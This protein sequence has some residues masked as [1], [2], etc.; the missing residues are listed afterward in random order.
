MSTD[1]APIAADPLGAA[2]PQVPVAGRPAEPGATGPSGRGRFGVLYGAIWLVY[3]SYP[4]TSAWSAEPGWRR[5]V[6][7]LST[8]LFAAVFVAALV[9]RRRTRGHP[10]RVPTVWWWATLAVELLLVVG[11]GLAADE[12]ALTGLV[13]MAVTAVFVLPGRSA[14]VVVAALVLLGEAVPRLLT[15]WDSIDSIGVQIVLASAAIFGFTQLM[16]RNVELARARGELADLAVARERERIARDVHDLLGHSLTVITVKAELAG[17]LLEV[18]RA[19]AAQEVADV[20]A[21]ARGALADVRATVAGFRAIGLA[22][23]LASARAVLTAAGLEVST[24]T[25]VDAVPESL[26]TLFAWVVREGVTNVLRHADAR[27]CEITVDARAVVVADDGHGP[28]G[29]PQAAAQ[30]VP[31]SG[32]VG[33]RERAA[34]AGAS[35]Q[36]GRSALGGFELRVQVP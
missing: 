16:S 26:R 21:L 8:V 27:R 17:R 19:R 6:S 36:V 7:L 10:A 12:S 5:V 3:L 29:R 4:L 15:G 33:L 14:L 28:S 32:L 9:A 1:L 25:A 22:G 13:F 30:A 20:E 11:M 23:E 31:G 34:A 2:H 35:V 24:P 18:D